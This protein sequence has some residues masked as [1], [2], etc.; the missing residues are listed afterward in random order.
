MLGKHGLK[1]GIVEPEKELP[2]L[3]CNHSSMFP[4][5]GS[6]KRQWICEFK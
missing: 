1:T 5:H 2:I 4:K 3:L 6:Y